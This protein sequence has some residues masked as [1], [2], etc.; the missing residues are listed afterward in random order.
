[1]FGIDRP[2]GVTQLAGL[3]ALPLAGTATGA[4][5]DE[6]AADAPCLTFTT[7]GTTSGP[8]LVL[9]DQQTIAGHAAD[10]ARHIGLDAPDAVLLGAVPF[11]GTFGNAAAMAAVAGGAHIVCLNQFD[12]EAAAA[13]IRQHRISQVIGGDDMFGRIAAASGGRPFE[14]IRFSGFAAFHSTA[15]ASIAAAEAAGDRHTGTARRGRR[16]GRGGG[17]RLR[18]GAGGL[19]S[20]N[21]WGGVRRG[22]APGRLP[23]AIGAI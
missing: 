7:S 8:K 21:R 20:P 14:T 1:V 16:T 9:H 22:G 18:S 3:P 19:R 11:C 17:G 12:G 5:P 10:V 15:T 6:S 23:P 13:L 2:A 4:G